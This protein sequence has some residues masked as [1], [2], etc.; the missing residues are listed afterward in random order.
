MRTLLFLFIMLVLS[1]SVP[2]MAADDGH[3][4]EES[5]PIQQKQVGQGHDETDHKEHGDTHKNHEDHAEEGSDHEEEGGHSEA[6]ED[7]GGH[8]G[9]GEHGEESSEVDLSPES[10]KEAGILVEP[11]TMQNLEGEIKAPGEVHLN[12]YLSSKV[13][14]RIGAQVIARHAKLGDRVE[15]GQPLVTLS[16]VEMAEAVGELLVAHK[17][18]ERVR[19]LGSAAVS[20]KRYSEA[21]VADE[22]ALAKVMA[23]GMTEVQV[24]KL[25]DKGITG[26]PGEFQLLAM[27]GGMIVSDD[28]IE[29]ELIEPGRVLF[30][31]VNES[32]L[33]VE[34]RLSPESSKNVDVGASARIHVPGNGWLQGKVVQKHHLLD[35][36]TRTIGVRIEVD[37]EEDR[38][39]PGM[40]VDTGIQ[41]GEEQKYLAVPTASVLRSPDGDWVVFVEGKPGQFKP[42]E[43]QVLRT[44][45]D[46]TVIDGLPEGTRVVTEGAFFVQ[47]EL[48]K[49]GFAVHNH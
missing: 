24:Q 37:N 35:E 42:Q 41:T 30:D 14:P 21:Q 23:Y 45:E 31:I 5:A 34:S 25:H 3:G 9:H 28:F 39:H 6:S 20:A 4:H 38:L 26:N 29:G 40:Y 12:S 33:W 17:E 48:A 7:K 16:S 49:S 32:V 11:L 1:F 27:Q 19:Q 10:L 22:Q 15:K 13:T 36:E 8:E 44:I 2:V 18:W 43:V 46:Y 47:S